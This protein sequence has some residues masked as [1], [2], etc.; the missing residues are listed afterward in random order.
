MTTIRKTSRDLAVTIQPLSG[1]DGEYLA[2]FRSEPLEATL[3][4]YF[5][6]SLM[7]AIALH[8]F[9]RNAEKGLRGQRCPPGAL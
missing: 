7:G 8:E 9:R 2:Y 4:V 6:D 1:R 5:H 3:S